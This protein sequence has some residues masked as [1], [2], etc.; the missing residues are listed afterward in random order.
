MQYRPEIDGL[1]AVAVLPVILFHAGFS[2]FSGGYVGVDIF[3]VISGYLITSI[4]IG[5]LDRGAF[6]IAKFYERRARRILPALFFVLLC[7]IPFAWIWMTPIQFK[8]FSEA[9]IAIAFFASNILFWKQESYFGQP[10]EEN[11]LLHTWSLAVEEQ[12][13]IF[14]PIMLLLLWRFGQRPIFWTIVL[15]SAC[16]LALSEWG[17]RNAPGGNFYLLPTRAWELGAGALCA[18]LLYDRPQKRSEWLA[19]IGLLLIIGSIVGYNEDTPF[20]SL[21]ALAPVAGTALIILFAPRE[22]LVGRL[23]QT[24]ALVGIGLV[25]FSAYLWH[26]PLLA[27]AR[28][29]SFSAP[30]PAVMGTLSAVSLA[31]AYL[32]W[33]FVETPFRGRGGIDLSRRRIFAMSGVATL[34]LLTTGVIGHTTNGLEQRLSEDQKQWMATME[35]LHNQRL[36]S[37]KANVCHFAPDLETLDLRAFT[38]QWDCTGKAM[39]GQQRLAVYGDSHAADKAAALRSAGFDPMQM[40]GSRCPLLPNAK[41]RTYCN[42]T[43]ETLLDAAQQH[44]VDTIVIANRFTETELNSTHLEAIMTF[45]SG[46][47]DNVILFTPMPE[48][49]GFDTKYSVWGNE[50]EQIEADRHFHDRFGQVLSKLDLPDNVRIAETGKYFCGSSDGTPCRPIQNGTVM[51]TDYGHL[52][53]EGAEIF[54]AR[55]VQDLDLSAG[56]LAEHPN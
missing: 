23:L 25:S 30:S 22:T 56:L 2:W 48:F 21:Y 55:L 39:P 35:T 29:A 13:Y 52:S 3:F 19:G 28:I 51:L 7:C 24:R 53:P 49:P 17:W 44:G 1:R 6:S 12:F 14:F 18:L 33:R 36:D 27:F 41:N 50:A 42:T 4:L 9:F 34:F 40:G 8:D 5:D 16:S 31:L 45:W 11:P 15:L 43:L 38:E 54:G 20:P 46:H 37:V 47:F 32:S 10:A 26:Q